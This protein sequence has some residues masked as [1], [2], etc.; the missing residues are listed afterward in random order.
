MKY[1]FQV[2][3]FNSSKNLVLAR[4]YDN[5]KYFSEVRYEKPLSGIYGRYINVSIGNFKT[6]VVYDQ[7]KMR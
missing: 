1:Y 4:Q 3:V 5:K 6:Y 2:Q 7:S